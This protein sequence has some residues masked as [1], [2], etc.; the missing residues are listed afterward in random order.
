MRIDELYRQA[1][2]VL[3]QLALDDE[4]LN[5]AEI[6]GRICLPATNLELKIKINTNSLSLTSIRYM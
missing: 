6:F 2:N 5:L 4:S 3:E 1:V